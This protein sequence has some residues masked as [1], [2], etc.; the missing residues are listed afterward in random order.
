[1]INKVT[2]HQQSSTA[3]LPGRSDVNSGGA[4]QVVGGVM[5]R[6]F[7]FAVAYLNHRPVFFFNRSFSPAILNIIFRTYPKNK[8]ITFS[9]LKK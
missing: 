2:E 3:E 5:A 7:P 1:V 4:S 8:E 6:R 9:G